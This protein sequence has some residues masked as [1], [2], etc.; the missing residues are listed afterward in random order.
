M[1]LMF[2]TPPALPDKVIGPSASLKVSVVDGF[3]TAFS[4]A[5]IKIS[6]ASA[7]VFPSKHEGPSSVTLVAGGGCMLESG[8]AKVRRLPGIIITVAEGDWFRVACTCSSHNFSNDRNTAESFCKIESIAPAQASAC[9]I[10]RCAQKRTQT[11]DQGDETSQ[12]MNC[13][14]V[15]SQM[16]GKQCAAL[17]CSM[18]HVRRTVACYCT[19]P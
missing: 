12:L 17:T 14:N 11:S 16:T 3:G 15:I 19:L 8:S 7:P 1:I 6:L 2:G 13:I 4:M 9:P 5:D 10:C 18:T